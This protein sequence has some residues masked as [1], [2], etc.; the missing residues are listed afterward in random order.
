M[1]IVLLLLFF[2]VWIFNL[3]SHNKKESPNIG[4]YHWTTKCKVEKD[5]K[6]ELFVKILDISFNQKLKVIKTSCKRD[7]IPVVYIDN[8]VFKKYKDIDRLVLLVKKH[9]KD[10]KEVQFDCDWSLK[11][12]ASYFYFLSQFKTYNLSATIRLHQIKYFKTTGVPPVNSGVL[13]FYNM[14]DFLDIKT[15]NYVLDLKVA[16]KY[17]YNFDIYPLSLDIALPIYSMATIIRDGVVIGMID[18]VKS[19][20]ID[21]KFKDIGNNTYLSKKTHYFQ[22][23][24]LYEGDILRVDEVEKSDLQKSIKLLKKYLKQKPKRVIFYR[25]GSEYDMKFL[26]SLVKKI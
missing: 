6:H 14:S 17:F 2:I 10:F 23:Q 13:M 3:S 26:E 12:R 24:L 9:L 16:K 11:T 1:K 15:K 8:N 4:F 19:H 25:L 7:F 18:T 5:F 20:M 21:D 22:K